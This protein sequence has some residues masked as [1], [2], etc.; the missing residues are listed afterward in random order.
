MSD[1]QKLPPLDWKAGL[2]ER[3]E[4]FMTCAIGPAYKQGVA[5]SY[6]AALESRCQAQAEQIQHL[7]AQLAKDDE[8][9]G[10]AAQ[11]AAGFEDW[12]SKRYP[13]QNRFFVQFEKPGIREAWEAALTSL[14]APIQGEDGSDEWFEEEVK[15]YHF[16]SPL[17]RVSYKLFARQVWKAAL[18]RPSAPHDTVSLRPAFV[19]QEYREALAERG[20]EVEGFPAKPAPHEA[21][22]GAH[23]FDTWWDSFWAH[24]LQQYGKLA[25]GVH[26]IAMQTW[27]TAQAARPL[28]PP[29]VMEAA[30]FVKQ[31]Y[32]QRDNFKANVVADWTLSFEPSPAVA[33]KV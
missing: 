24:H 29:E 12:C 9:M 8:R 23:P 26:A 16:L 28:P 27:A 14:Q 25:E 17:Q 4:W 21:G 5:D 20:I 6:L 18:A 31:H 1:T 15:S 30:R 33:E 11:K 3:P 32:S 10:D 19:S 22:D 7:M 2:P 13:K